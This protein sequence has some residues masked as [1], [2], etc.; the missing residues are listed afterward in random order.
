MMAFSAASKTSTDFTPSSLEIA[1][2]T[3]WVHSAQS[4][5]FMGTSRVCM[6]AIFDF[7][8]VV[9]CALVNTLCNVSE[10]F[11]SK[12]EQFS[13]S[14]VAQFIINKAA[15]LFRNNQSAVL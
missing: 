12:Q 3:C 15:L 6:S 4:I 1:C 11:I 9:T 8:W 2:C 10:Q 13:N 5:P 7:P 14:F